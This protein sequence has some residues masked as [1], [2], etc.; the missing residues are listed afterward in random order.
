MYKLFNVSDSACAETILFYVGILPISYQID[1]CK[2]RFY[3]YYTRIVI[4]IV[5][6]FVVMILCGTL[7][8]RPLD[9]SLMSY[10]GL[11]G[12][13]VRRSGSLTNA[14]RSIS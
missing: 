2:L 4:C 10:S 14:F 7:L 6:M 12:K 9:V 11:T 13:Q 5:I 8:M 1:L 3:Y